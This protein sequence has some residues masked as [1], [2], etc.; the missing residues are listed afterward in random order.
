[1]NTGPVRK[2]RITGKR[3][4]RYLC[5]SV[6]ASVLILR[7]ELLAVDL[8]EGGEHRNDQRSGKDAQ[9]T[10]D[11]QATQDADEEEE[12]GDVRLPPDK[13][14]FKKIIREGHEHDSPAC[15][16]ET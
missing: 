12:H 16:Q 8:D 3:C 1:M 10:V 6:V 9:K 4:R 15:Q 5:P 14:G 13:K 2:E 7:H 11:L